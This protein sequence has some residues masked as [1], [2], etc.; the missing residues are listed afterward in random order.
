MAVRLVHSERF[1]RLLRMDDIDTIGIPT[2]TLVEQAIEEGRWEDAERLLEYMELEFRILK[3]SVIAGWLQDVFGYLHERLGDT[4]LAEANRV[5]RSQV[6]EAFSSLSR[7]F[8]ADTRTAIRARD[9]RGARQ[10][11]E[12]MRQTFKRINDLCIHWIQ[13][14]LTYLVDRYGEDELERVLRVSYETIWT[15]RYAGWDEWPVEEKL[16]VTLEGM[17][18]HFSGPTR[19]GEVTVV[20]EGD[21]YTLSF[22]PC[23]TGGIIRRG[24]V[25]VGGDP[26]PTHGVSTEPKPYNWFQEG[27]PHYCTHCSAYLEVFT[28]RDF[29]YPIRPLS[30][31]PDPSKPCVWHVYK[32]KHL[33]RDE[34]FEKIGATRPDDWPSLAAARTSLG[35]SQ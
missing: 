31:N 11:M 5:P 23:G 14:M 21:R 3:E 24:D 9:E 35:F 29:K 17:R 18:N 27:V 13:D 20:D 30:F 34:H 19:R 16:A 4:A 28:L 32:H 1:G 8:Q 6:W 25:E 26:W 7:R 15:T 10:G 33:T 2:Q 12:Y 22:D